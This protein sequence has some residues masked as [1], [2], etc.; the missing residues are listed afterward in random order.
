[1]AMTFTC[2]GELCLKI[3][4]VDVILVQELREEKNVGFSGREEKQ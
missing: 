3:K 1:M 4:F 2:R